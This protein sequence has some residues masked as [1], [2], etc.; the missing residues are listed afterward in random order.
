ML[1]ERVA[2]ALHNVSCKLK[3]FGLRKIEGGK[4]LIVH[5]LVYKL[6]DFRVFAALFHGIEAAEVAYGAQ[7]GVGTVQ[8][9]N[10]PLMVR[11]L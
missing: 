4:K 8:E 3:E 11:S 2:E 7:D 1:H 5:H 9:G 6:A 10:L